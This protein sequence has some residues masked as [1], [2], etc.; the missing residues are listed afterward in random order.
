MGIAHGLV[1]LQ[2]LSFARMCLNETSD[3]S[4]Y[5]GF[6]VVQECFTDSGEL[7]LAVRRGGIKRVLFNGS[8]VY[9]VSRHS[10][11]THNAVIAE[12]IGQSEEGIVTRCSLSRRRGYRF[13]KG[14]EGGLWSVD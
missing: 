2:R 9:Q 10:L 11:G 13:R 8:L 12:V 1:A 14:F 3:H 7:A 4:L 5:V 6:D